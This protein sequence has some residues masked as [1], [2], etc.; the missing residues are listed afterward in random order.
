MKALLFGALVT[1]L[2]WGAAAEAAGRNPAQPHAVMS[3]LERAATECFAETVLSNPAATRHA[4]AGRWYEAAGITGFLCR[5]EVDAMIQAHDRLYGRGTGTR[6][7]QNA[8]TRHLGQQLAERLQ[9]M[10]ERKSVASA[11][12]PADK[13]EVQDGD[14]AAE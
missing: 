14:K 12:P 9:P 8:Y 2:G 13:A 7:F 11:E 1:T 10:L 4:R 5:P 6:Y 3:P